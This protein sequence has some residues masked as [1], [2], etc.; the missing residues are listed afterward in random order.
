MASMH[1]NQMLVIG[2]CSHDVISILEMEEVYCVQCGHT[3]P[4]MINL[5]Q[6]FRE[7]I[8]HF[9]GKARCI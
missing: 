2:S 8:E 9:R 3:S 6:L 4:D 5:K 7:V 1:E